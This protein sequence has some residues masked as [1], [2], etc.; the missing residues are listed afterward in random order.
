MQLGAVFPQTEI[1]ADRGGVRA[2]AQ[3]VQDMGFGHVL[4]Y[5]HV[6][7]ADPDQHPGFAGPYTHRSMF[8][9]VMV[10]MGFIAGVAPGL[11]LATTVVIAP[12]RQTALLAKQAAEL[13]VLSGGRL[14]LGMGLGWNAVEYEALGVP[15]AARGR[16]F[17]E[18]IE[19]LR[20][21]WTEPVV[22][23]AGRFH[24]VTGAGLNPLPVQKPI[25]IW[26][27]ANSER[28]MRRAVRIADGFMPLRP[29]E[30]GWERTFE[31]IG[32]WLA[33]QGRDPASLGIEPSINV[34]RGTPQEWRQ[35]AS[36]WRERGASH[37]M[38]NTMGGGLQGP[39]AHIQALAGALEALR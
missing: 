23:F 20:R 17:E 35:A 32:G 24:T 10:L 7:G 26:I 1:G 11:G 33:E 19:L 25:P 13:D 30:G 16:R 5:D 15:W 28:A 37:L 18:Q 6:L 22:N 14:R 34:S 21:L 36:E 39:D 31:L 3:A 29:L 2:Y 9:E 27:G 12:Q 4:A 38:L 8:H